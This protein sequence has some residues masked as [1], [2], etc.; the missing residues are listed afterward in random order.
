MRCGILARAPATWCRARIGGLGHLG[1]QYARQMGFETVAIN[2]G[3]DKEPLAR[4]LGA[5][6]MTIDATANDVRG[7]NY[8]NLGARA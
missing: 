2:R 7:L 6:T 5:H 3:N 8:R 4:K 1:V